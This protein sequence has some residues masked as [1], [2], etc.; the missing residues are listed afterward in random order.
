MEHFYFLLGL[1]TLA[2]LVFLRGV[3]RSLNRRRSLPYVADTALF[4]P[5][6][7][8]FKT[9]LEQSLGKDYR[10]YGRVRVADIIGVQAHLSR[11]EAERAQAR[12]GERSFDF[13]ICS[14]DTT[15]IV[16]AVNLSSPA[17]LRKPL[18]KDRLDRI[19]AAAQLPF[20]RFQESEVYAVADIA[21]R[22]GAILYARHDAEGNDTNREL[23]LEDTAT[24]LHGLSS[25]IRDRAAEAA[26]LPLRKGRMPSVRRDWKLFRTLA[27][28]VREDDI[29]SA[30]KTRREPSI[31]DRQDI[32]A[33]PVFHFDC[34][35]EEVSVRHDS[36]RRG[37]SPSGGWR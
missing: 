34:E 15:A 1:G 21:E 23:P 28:P 13:L 26:D 25:A 5:A 19:C 11:R 14:P 30:A 32:D 29:L 17:W 33:G 3:I 12:L 37:K 20:A 35:L 6:Q 31:G 16:C 2:L 4:T 24:V 9:A 7:R 36:P 27:H 18:L 8:I 10:V 22:I